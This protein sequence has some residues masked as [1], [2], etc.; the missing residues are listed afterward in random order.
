[1]DLRLRWHSGVHSSQGH[2]PDIGS[3]E[4]SGNPGQLP[5][6]SQ[7]KSKVSAEDF[8]RGVPNPAPFRAAG[9]HA[10]SVAVGQWVRVLAELSGAR[11]ATTMKIV[12]S[13]RS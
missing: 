12:G 10:G 7:I 13:F 4:N 3:S 6:R 2:A 11:C 1:M 5:T 8:F 9:D